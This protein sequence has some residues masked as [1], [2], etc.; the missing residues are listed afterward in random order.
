MA[1]SEL[2]GSECHVGGGNDGVEKM[3]YLLII[4]AK[5]DIA[6]ATA[7][8]FARNGFN[9]YLGGRGD[10][11]E[12]EGLAADLHIRYN[13]TVK[14]VAIELNDFEKHQANYDALNPKP[15]GVLCTAGYLGNQQKAEENIKE[16]LRVI[17]ANYSGCVSLLNV[18]ANDFEKRKSG[19]IIGVSSVAGERGRKSNYIYGSAKAGFTAYLSGL[20]NRLAGMGIKVLTVKPGFVKTKM[21]AGL[22]LPLALTVEP[23]QVAD[24]VFKAWKKGRD[25]LYVKSLWRWI[26][27]ALRLIPERIFK[28]MNL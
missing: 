1:P 8:I 23:Q 4:G 15:V 21:T 9:L 12:L 20:R 10:L 17:N 19:F 3:K 28:K 16:T 11:H 24:A 18:I 26:M 25:V 14:V 7:R 27:L 22:E 2:W 6:E 13:V 5:S